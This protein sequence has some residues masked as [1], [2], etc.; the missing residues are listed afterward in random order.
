MNTY[1]HKPNRSGA[2]S[3]FLAFL[4]LPMLAL[5]ALSVDYGF[6]LYVRTDLQRTADQAVIAA[7]RD[8]VPDEDGNQDLDAVRAT[9][10]TYVQKNLGDGFAVQDSDIEIGRYERSSIYTSLT[11]LNDGILD[12]I[13]VTLRRDDLA[14]NSVSLYFARL[15]DKDNSDITVTAAGILQRARYLPPGSSVLPITIEDRVWNRLDIGDSASIYGDGRIEDEAGHNIPG[16]WGTVDIGVNGNST[17]DLRDQILYGLRQEDLN[18]LYNQGSIPDSS[19]IDSQQNPLD[20]NGDTGFSAGIKNAIGQV[21]GTVKYM[22]IYDRMHGQGGN[23]DFE[24]IGWGVVNLVNS[25]FNGNNNSFVEVRK[26]YVYDGLL[27]PDPDLSSEAW[28]IDGAF[29]SP[30]LV[31]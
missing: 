25:G 31:Q 21:H 6:L 27:L 1:K 3:A 26:V 22:P 15:F 7:L 19:S 5:L 4:M 24:V 9:L 13:R 2:I 10:R 20:L 23:L 17:N 28:A 29:T 18:A 30:V 16:N 8:L 14:N 11:I 12:T